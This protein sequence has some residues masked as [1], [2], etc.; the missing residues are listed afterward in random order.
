M[1]EK[2]LKGATSLFFKPFSKLAKRLQPEHIK[3]KRKKQEAI[4]LLVGVWYDC[5]WDLL[6]TKVGR[7]TSQKRGT[8]SPKIKNISELFLQLQKNRMKLLRALKNKNTPPGNAILHE[9][10]KILKDINMAVTNFEVQKTIRKLEK[11]EKANKL[12]QNEF[13]REFKKLDK[14]KHPKARSSQTLQN[15]RKI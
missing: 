1:T 11:L 14:K 6:E 3:S 13:W 5:I 12:G 2:N 8:G 7:K 10:K 9:R 15:S 4:D